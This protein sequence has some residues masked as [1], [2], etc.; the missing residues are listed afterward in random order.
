MRLFGVTG[1]TMLAGVIGVGLYAAGNDDYYGGGVTRWAHATKDGGTALLVALFA[2][3]TLI[4]LA[5]VSVGFV[6]T[7]RPSEL[8]LVPAIALY[9]LT[10]FYVLAVLSVGH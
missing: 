4:S 1:L 6:R 9:G 7:R 5:L 2:V 10:L 3:P 8:L